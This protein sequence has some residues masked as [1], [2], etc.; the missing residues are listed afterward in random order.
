[1]IHFNLIR[2]LVVLLLCFSVAESRTCD[3]GG[4]SSTHVCC[5]L[6]DYCSDGST[7]CFGRMDFLY[8]Q[9]DTIVTLICT[10]GYCP[11]CGNPNP[12]NTQDAVAT[13]A[14][15]DKMFTFFNKYKCWDG[16]IAASPGSSIQQL[17]Q[18]TWNQ[19]VTTSMCLVRSPVNGGYATTFTPWSECNNACVSTRARTCTS[20]SPAY[21]GED[22]NPM[23]I[24]ETKSCTGCS[25]TSSTGSARYGSTGLQGAAAVATGS[26]WIAIVTLCVVTVL[27]NG[28]L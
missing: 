6:K 15:I 11:I 21:G 18:T 12:A 16:Q 27:M 17:N 19:K 5:N 1:M 23:Q 7:D 26:V 13:Q 9:A 3:V 2:C 25:I 24:V 20:P 4:V 28:M 8:S 10:P 22:C 14:L